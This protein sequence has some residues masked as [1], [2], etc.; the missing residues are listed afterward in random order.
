M[1]VILAICCFRRLTVEFVGCPRI[2]SM[3]MGVMMARMASW[4]AASLVVGKDIV[5]VMNRV[6][7]N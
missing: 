2:L 1:T 6:V 5:L 7:F 3:G 4:G